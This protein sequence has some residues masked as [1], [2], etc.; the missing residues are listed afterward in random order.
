[1]VITN[2]KP[3]YVFSLEDLTDIEVACHDLLTLESKLLAAGFK[4]VGREW[5][6]SKPVIFYGK[7]PMVYISYS[8]SIDDEEP[9]FTVKVV[10]S[11]GDMESWYYNRT[12]GRNDMIQKVDTQLNDQLNRFIARGLIKAPRKQ[13][14]MK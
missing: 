6:Y 7:T 4:K 1:M 5:R 8:C 14:I 3:Y 12:Y 11:N 13:S 9:L 2:T 10:S